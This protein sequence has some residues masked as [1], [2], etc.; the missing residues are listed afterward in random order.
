M[1]KKYPLL[2][3][4]NVKYWYRECDPNWSQKDIA[5]KVG[6]APNVISYFMIT[7]NIPTRN[8]SEASLNRFKC[9]RK[10]ENH[11]EAMSQEEVRNNRSKA[12]IKA[13]QK[14]DAIN[15]LIRASRKNLGFTQFKILQVLYND[16]NKSLKDL[17]NNLH[18]FTRKQLNS[19]L[20]RLSTRGFV[21]RKKNNSSKRKRYFYSITEKGRRIY[22]DNNNEETIRNLKRRREI[23]KAIA[24]SLTGPRLGNVQAKILS[25]I[26]LKGPLYS[27]EIV[28]ELQKKSISS[29]TTKGSLSRMIKNKFLFRTLKFNKE[30]SNY[31][32]MEFKYS[33]N[34]YNGSVHKS[35]KKLG[36][37]QLT[38][39]NALVKSK[40]CFL[41]ELTTKSNFEG[42]SKSAIGNALKKLCEDQLINRVKKKDVTLGKNYPMKYF[43]R[44]NRLGEKT[45]ELIQ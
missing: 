30:L 15:N 13:W 9:P 7:N 12:M 45:F 3:I 31:N 39:L 33:L 35:Y 6:C 42:F 1:T 19:T 21:T 2:T 34:S 32:K 29:G 5:S 17:A 44:I 24:L 23:N 11:R 16:S 28:S 27:S 36:V 26:E 41:R 40:G 25:L 20:R 18:S 14:P 10:L 8:P 4:Q 43:Y 38:I 37:I 22:D